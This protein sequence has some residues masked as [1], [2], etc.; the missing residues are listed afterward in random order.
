MDEQL[1]IPEELY[2]LTVNEKTGRKAY[3]KSKK[4]DLLLAAAIL[5]D[6]ALRHRIDTDLERVITDQPG[7]TGHLLLDEALGEIHST[8]DQQKIN[9]WL[10][11]LATKGSRFRE[12]LVAGLVEKGFLRMER[13]YVF[14]LFRPGTR[15]ILIKNNEIMAVRERIRTL[16]FS[17][18]LPDFR[19]MVIVSAA[20]YGGLLDLVLSSEEIRLRQTR[21]ELLAR[22]DMI[23]Q[24][25]SQSLHDFTRSVILIMRTREILGFT[26]PEEK[27]A[28]LV[29][30]M[31]ALMHLE[32]DEDMPEWLRKGTVQYEKTL[33][34][35]RKTGTNEIVFN[36]KTGQ[37]GLKA[38][39]GTG[40]TF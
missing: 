23:G 34:F 25:V 32:R 19:D 40:A 27:L 16:I 22:M 9:W 26:T 29:E 1:T 13:E 18:N 14:P 10:M 3:L 38:G 4:F 30:E 6:L 24:A 36:P 17:D 39:A 37:Y 11:K 2:L 7:P 33:E 31:K 5:M 12:I 28:E 8:P 35:I 21:I 20:W 15:T